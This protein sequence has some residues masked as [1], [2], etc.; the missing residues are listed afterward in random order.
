MPKNTVDILKKYKKILVPEVNMGQL[1]ALIKMNYL[2]DVIQ[3]NK[4]KGTPFKAA[5]IESKIEETLKGN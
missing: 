4:V 3:Y 1:A 2:I 5:E